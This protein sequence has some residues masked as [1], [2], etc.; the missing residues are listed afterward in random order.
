MCTRRSAPAPFAGP[1]DAQSSLMFCYSPWAAVSSWTPPQ[2]SCWHCRKAIA[3]SLA[4]QLAFRQASSLASDFA[5]SWDA[6]DCSG[7]IPVS[8]NSPTVHSVPPW[9]PDLFSALGDI[10]KVLLFRARDESS[11]QNR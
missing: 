8:G 2:G 6:L 1:V 7:Q 4:T 10:P 9:R 5:V 3:L 11:A